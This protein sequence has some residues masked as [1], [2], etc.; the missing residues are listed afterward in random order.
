LDGKADGNG[1]DWETVLDEEDEEEV[2]KL[3]DEEEMAA[4]GVVGAI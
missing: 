1:I 3:C 4:E 2:G